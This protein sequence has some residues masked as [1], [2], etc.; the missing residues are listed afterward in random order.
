MDVRNLH[1]YIG[2]LVAAFSLYGFVTVSVF[3]AQCI[4]SVIE[5]ESAQEE[6]DTCGNTEAS[7]TN[8]LYVMLTLRCE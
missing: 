6:I 7:Q 8:W 1:H 2:M 5:F 4:N 3:R